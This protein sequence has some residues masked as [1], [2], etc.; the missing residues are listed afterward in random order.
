MNEDSR[1]EP[2]AGGSFFALFRASCAGRFCPRRQNYFFF[3]SGGPISFSSKRNG[4]KNAAKNPWFLDFLPPIAGA[5]WFVRN[6]ELTYFSERCRFCSEMRRCAVLHFV[7]SAAAGIDAGQFH[8]SGDLHFVAPVWDAQ[9]REILCGARADLQTAGLNGVF[10]HFCRCWQQ[11]VA[12]GRETSLT[13]ADRNGA[14][15][16]TRPRRAGQNSA[17]TGSRATRRDAEDAMR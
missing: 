12:P 14:A 13:A 7:F 1:K 16:G 2:P 11:W 8:I 15:G 5:F 10:A 3:A 4:E 17:P 9:T 6:V